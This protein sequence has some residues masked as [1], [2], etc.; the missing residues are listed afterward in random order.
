MEILKEERDKAREQLI[1]QMRAL[2]EAQERSVDAFRA[3]HDP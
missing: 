2:Q 3:Q 1:S